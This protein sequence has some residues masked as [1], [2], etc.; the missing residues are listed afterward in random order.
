M[1]DVI[2][3]GNP[4]QRMDF[5]TGPVHKAVHSVA[6][7]IE[8]HARAIGYPPRFAAVKLSRATRRLKRR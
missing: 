2:K 7:L 4:G 6:H 1:D 3:N 5:C 8:D